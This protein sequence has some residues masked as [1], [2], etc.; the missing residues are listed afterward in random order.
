LQYA[1]EIADAL[2]KQGA[3][4]RDVRLEGNAVAHCLDPEKPCVSVH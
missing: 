3:S 4:I 1:W 2:E